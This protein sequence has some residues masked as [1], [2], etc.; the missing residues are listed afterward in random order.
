MRAFKVYAIDNGTVIDHIPGGKALKVVEI[1]KLEEYNQVV[2]VGMNFESKKTV[3][4]DVVKIENKSL[5]KDELNR[6]AVIAPMATINIIRE[7]KVAEKFKIEVPKYMENL[8][9]CPNPKCITRNEPV[10]TKFHKE[11]DR[12][13]TVKCHYCE[14]SFTEFTLC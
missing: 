2:T 6:I 7:Q 5:S 11:A 3:R 9:R 12:P 1:L 10:A 4:K 8:I 13:L 14:K